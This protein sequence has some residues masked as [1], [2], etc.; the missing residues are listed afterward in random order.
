VSLRE[1]SESYLLRIGVAEADRYHVF[2]ALT[3]FENA[4]RDPVFPDGL[5]SQ[6]WQDLKAFFRREVPRLMQPDRKL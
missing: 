6:D 1:A 4:E 5:T 2:R 3:Y